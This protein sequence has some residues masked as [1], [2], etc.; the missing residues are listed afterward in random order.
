MDDLDLRLISLLRHDGRRSVSELAGDLKV[1]RATVRSRMEKLVDT[2]EI[3]GFTAVLRD[4][5][6]DLPIR[7]VTLVVVDGHN[8]EPVIR[9]LSA[10]TEVRAIHSTNGKWDLVLDVATR[11]L[12]AFDDALNRIRLIEGITGTET[13]LLLTTRK[14]PA[15]SASEFKDVLR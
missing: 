4:D 2:G 13:S 5:W 3:L 10:M 1:S 15:V 9:S 12:A 6:R 8:T 7:A 14:G 11:D